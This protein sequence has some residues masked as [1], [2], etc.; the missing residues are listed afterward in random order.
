MSTGTSGRRNDD[1]SGDEVEE[2]S[3]EA[4]IERLTTE[5]EELKASLIGVKELSDEWWQIK[6]DIKDKDTE[7]LLLIE[8]KRCD[9]VVEEYFKE[10]PHVFEAAPECPICL[11]KI[12]STAASVQYVCCGKHIC[13]TCDSQAGSVL[14]TCPLCREKVPG[15]AEETMSITKEK[16]D[17]GIAWAQADRGKAYLYGRDGVPEDTERALPLLREAAEKGSTSAKNYL[18][19]HYLEVENYEESRRWYEAAAA[20]G[21]MYSLCQL[22]TMMMNGQAF[23]Q[24][25]QSEE[26]ELRILTICTTLFDGALFNMVAVELSRYFHDSLPVMLHYLRP[27]LEEGDTSAEV[28]GNYG[29]GLLSVA[30]EY[31]GGNSTMTPGFSPVPEA[32]FWFQQCSEKEELGANHPLVRIESKNRKYCAFCLAGI[33]KGKQSCCVECKAAYYC[34]RDCQVAHWKAGHK[35]DCVRKLK[36]RLK[37]K[38]KLDEEK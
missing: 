20:E 16:A 10:N 32:L 5:I 7:K 11:D 3:A 23:D 26:E 4:K 37:A 9:V 38:G 25:E 12:W 24:N 14:D 13:K 31:Y 34:S 17:A 21:D 1:S 28:I 30:M 15:S 18:G 19:N 36:K 22:G 6:T 2:E 29:L 27:A 8:K 35:N 33:P